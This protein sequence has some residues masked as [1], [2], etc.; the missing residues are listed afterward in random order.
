MTWGGS[1]KP[2]SGSR[3]VSGTFAFVPGSAWTSSGHGPS[4]V[5]DEIRPN[6]VCDALR[7]LGQRSKA[8]G[9]MGRLHSTTNTSQLKRLV[10][11]AVPLKVWLMLMRSPARSGT[12][13]G[14]Q[15]DPAFTAALALR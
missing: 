10:E 12:F 11:A 1:P 2:R 5:F 4:G 8:W 9:E 6:R 15:P 3:S 13:R 7:E 14:I